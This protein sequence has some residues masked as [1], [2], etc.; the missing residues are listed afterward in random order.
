MISIKSD[1]EFRAMREAG[2]IVAEVLAWAREG[3][4]AGMT[5]LDID[6]EA[7][8]IIRAAGATPEFKG[9][10]GF[11]ASICA[12]V[13]DEVV[14]GIPGKRK[15]KSGDVIG[16][17]VGARWGGFVGDAAITLAVGKVTKEAERLIE[18]CRECLD[19]AIAATAP[20]ARLSAIGAAVQ[21]HAE[22]RGYTLV[23]E[24]AGHGIGRHMH[25]EPSVPNYVDPR[26]RHRDH[27]LRPGMAICIEPMVNQ[28]GPE[29][30]VL[31]DDWTV[32]TRDGSLSA[33][34][35]H[36]VAIKATGAEVMT[37]L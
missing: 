18:T 20:G 30:R 24:Y 4:K 32:V 6:T 12:S 8:R 7:E 10:R 36:T 11:P 27:V 21:T 34:F 15:L 29:V 31:D 1:E 28:G 13:N 22:S 26:S 14:H 5:T 16:V 23:R 19:L 9:Y 37:V 35:E 25:E 17:D 3:V 33:H 2:R